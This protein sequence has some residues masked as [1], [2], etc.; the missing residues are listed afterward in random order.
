M[1]LNFKVKL[2]YHYCI[3]IKH[4]G[5]K[6]TRRCFFHEIL[7]IRHIPESPCKIRIKKTFKF[8]A[9]VSYG[10]YMPCS[11]R[12][13]FHTIR[14]VSCTI[15]YVFSRIKQLQAPHTLFRCCSAFQDLYHLRLLHIHVCLQMN[16]LQ[17]M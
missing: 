9:H 14:Y 16:S 12:Y 15:R 17:N 6:I 13:V 5:D 2:I 7:V 10:S 8:S 4:W 3:S 1:H 11:I